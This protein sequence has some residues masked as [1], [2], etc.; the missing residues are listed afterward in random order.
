MPTSTATVPADSALLIATAS[1]RLAESG[2]NEVSKIKLWVLRPVVGSSS[3][4]EQLPLI[5]HAFEGVDSPVF[6]SD[7]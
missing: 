3:D 1:E 6:E 5:G 2:P 7:P 4:S